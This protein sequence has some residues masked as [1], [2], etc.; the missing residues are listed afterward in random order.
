MA[1]GSAWNGRILCTSIFGF[2]CFVLDSGLLL[3]V[4][5]HGFGVEQG[6]RV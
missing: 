3:R 1:L 4:D 2:L 6:F 5:L